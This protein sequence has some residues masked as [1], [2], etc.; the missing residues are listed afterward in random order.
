V[1]SDGRIRD[2]IVL[3]RRTDHDTAPLVGR[4]AELG[5]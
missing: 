4:L 3:G 5:L 2:E 1:I